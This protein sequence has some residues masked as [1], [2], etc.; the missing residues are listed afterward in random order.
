[1]QDRIRHRGLNEAKSKKKEQEYYRLLETYARFLAPFYN[2]FFLAISLGG[3]WKLREKVTAEISP[4]I[5]DRILDLA[6]GTGKQAISL[7]RKK[8]DVVAVD[9]SR[10]MINLIKNK[11]KF[12]NLAFVISDATKLPFTDHS[13]DISCVSFAL[14]DMI[15]PVREKAVVELVRV[16]REKGTITIVDYS[17]HRTRFVRFFSSIARLYEPYYSEFARY[18][19][20]NLVSNS[21]VRIQKEIEIFRGV[22]RILIGEKL[23]QKAKDENLNSLLL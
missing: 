12:G 5:G 19:L 14:H 13:F 11:N 23:S 1:M 22:G 7:A 16:T 9:L 21:G 10:Y 6:T 2:L 15:L 17:S 20:E 8:T 4:Q 3:E 18:D